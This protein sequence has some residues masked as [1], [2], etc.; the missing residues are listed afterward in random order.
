MIFFLFLSSVQKRKVNKFGA[1]RLRQMFNKGICGDKKAANRKQALVENTE[2]V[3]QI[4]EK[5]TQLKVL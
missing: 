1:Q 2:N 3:G 4:N 5:S